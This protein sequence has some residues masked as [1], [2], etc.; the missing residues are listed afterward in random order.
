M[1]VESTSVLRLL[2]RWI[3]RLVI[4][5]RLLSLLCFVG[6]GGLLGLYIGFDGVAMD[7]LH[8]CGTKHLEILVLC[9][10]ERHILIYGRAA[11]FCLLMKL[12]TIDLYEGNSMLKFQN[13]GFNDMVMPIE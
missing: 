9:L 6:G 13:R 8:I 3:V 5:S 1:P 2:R 4:S 12:T 11:M 10:S 7:F